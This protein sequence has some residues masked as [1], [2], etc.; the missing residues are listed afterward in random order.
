MRN[1]ALMCVLAGVVGALSLSQIACGGKTATKQTQVEQ[2]PEEAYNDSGVAHANNGDY[3]RAIAAYNE[4]IRLNP[5]YAEAYYNRGAAYYNK[6]DYSQAVMDW[7]STLRIDPSH[8]DARQNLETARKK[9][10]LNTFKGGNRPTNSDMEAMIERYGKLLEQCAVKTSSRCADVL[11]T[12]GSLYYDAEEPTGGYSKSL[13]M[14]WRLLDEYPTFPKIP[15]AL[16]QISIVYMLSGQ[17]DSASVILKQL[18]SRFPTSTRVSAAHFWLGSLAFVDNNLETAYDNFKKVRRRE[19]DLVSWE[20]VHYRMG[21]CAYNTGNYEK[22]IEHFCDYVKECDAGRYMKKEFRDNA[23][24]Y[25]RLSEGACLLGCGGKITQE[26]AA[27]AVNTTG[28]AVIVSDTVASA[29]DTAAALTP[30]TVAAAAP[31]TVKIYIDMVFVQGGKFTV[32]DR[33]FDEMSGKV[34]KT[35]REVTI[36]DF[37]IGKYECTQGLWKSVIGYNPSHFWGDDN[38]PVEEVSYNDIQEFIRKL[39]AKT[40]KKYRL[41][42]SDEW[43]YAA[44]G[45]K[46]S[47]GY[48][49]PGSN[50]VDEVAWYE[51]NSDEEPRPVGTKKPNELGIYDM[52]GNV[53]ERTSTAYDYDDDDTYRDYHVIRGGSW[54]YDARYCLIYS[55]LNG[56]NELSPNDVGFRLAHDADSFGKLED[57]KK[58]DSKPTTLKIDEGKP[59]DLKKDESKPADLK[60]GGDAPSYST[61]TDKRDKKVYKIVKIGGQNWFAENL[62]Y[63]AKGSKCYDNKAENCAKYGRLY[64]WETA[65]TACPVGY[66]LPTS[67]EWD[68][69]TNYAGGKRMAG[70]KLKSKSW[71]SYRGTPA[72]T[73]DYGFSALP[74]GNGKLDANFVSEY[75]DY[76]WS[77]AYGYWWSA[78]ETYYDDNLAWSLE[79]SCDYDIVRSD[80]TKKT[81]LYS[82]RCV[83]DDEKER[84]K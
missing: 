42:T 5:N 24:E 34:H 30:Q 40:G 22:A 57:L 69:L 52:G 71:K 12:L 59:T 3:D 1:F 31:E 17:L 14:Y 27:S 80:G 41:P 56:S 84:R 38:L 55:L 49:Y 16:L 63:D 23:L 18:V 48:V 64:N 7:E 82:V 54:D 19:I 8:T 79:L 72:A 37:L 53:M 32:E 78:T 65:L 50:N 36:G 66:H 21:E 25:I 74:G 4:A 2:T 68:T 29:P 77:A 20:T 13:Q 43:E 35:A 58:D 47:K 10:I 11:Y 75:Y 39:N 81:R 28:T 6:N 26:K 45:G 60:N 9:A 67:A 83:Q 76:S 73:D 62:N 70:T 46:K 44:R 33:I 51:D 15:E 61:F